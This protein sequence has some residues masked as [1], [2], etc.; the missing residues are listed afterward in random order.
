MIS[1]LPKDILINDNFVQ[2]I[3]IFKTMITGILIVV[4]F[5][6]SYFVISIVLK[7]RKIYFSII[8]ILGGTKKTCKRLLTLELCSFAILSVSIFTI[9][10]LLNNMNLIDIYPLHQI[11]K[12]MNV[13]DFVTIYLIIIAMSI[14][15]SIK[16]SKK[17][18][19][20]TVITSLRE[21]E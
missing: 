1:K 16:F 3:Q 14:L 21:D 19:K 7:S 13:K 10:L 6:I 5:F 4:L 8:R 20:N 11:S 2:F 12:Y 18:F 15:L 17:V 9:I